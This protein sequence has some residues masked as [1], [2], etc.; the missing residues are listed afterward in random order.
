MLGAN[1]VARAIYRTICVTPPNWSTRIGIYGSWGSGKTS[2]LNLLES[3][4]KEDQAIVVRFSAWAAS[5]ETGVLRQFYDALAKELEK[6]GTHRPKMAQAKR[7]VGKLRGYLGDLKGIAKVAEDW[8]PLPKGTADAA[9]GVAQTAFE[10]FAINKADLDALA[11]NLE[12]R[13]VVVF[14]D[15][16][17][18]ADPKLIPKTLLALREMLDW[19]NFSFVL[20]F[21]RKVVGSALAEY[22]K[23]YGENAQMFLEK[24]VDVPFEIAAPTAPQKLALASRAFSTCCSFVPA[25]IIDS[26]KVHLPD[27]PRRVKLV[28]RKIGVMASAAARHADGELD[29]RSIV[30]YNIVH[31]ASA[32][33]ARIVVEI[34]T[35]DEG[36]SSWLNSDEHKEEKIKDVAGKLHPAFARDTPNDAERPLKA[37][38]ELLTHWQRTEADAIKYQIRLAF[39]EPTFTA[40]EFEAIVFGGSTSPGMDRIASSVNTATTASGGP[41][42]SAANDLVQLSLQRYRVALSDM[43]DASVES[44]REQAMD[45]AGAILAFVEA[46]QAS[47]DPDVSTAMTSGSTASTL[48]SIAAHWANWTHNSGEKDLR[49]REQALAMIVATNCINQEQVYADTD[50]FWESHHEGDGPLPDAW[51]A[52]IRK[53]LQGPIFERLFSRVP[54]SGGITNVVRGDEDQGLQ[55][56]LLESVKSPLYSERKLSSAL[57]AQFVSTKPPSDPDS[58]ARRDSAKEYLHLLLGES[59]SGSWGGKEKIALVVENAPTLIVTA[60][61]AIARCPVPLRMISSI[62]KLRTEL[63]K[64]GVPAASLPVPRWLTAGIKQLRSIET[65]RSTSKN[66]AAEQGDS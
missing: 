48:V 52:K 61:Q 2:I 33:A 35:Q 22:S 6:E 58:I 59:R 53:K 32:E 13:R 4:A 63:V 19:P 10:A 29:W 20:A 28:A 41:R 66:K 49:K 56:W 54:Q 18:R 16:L 23:A 60:W 1:L 5:G 62:E 25:Q 26:V 3:L 47:T 9:F 21:D 44:D 37:A 34:A 45:R 51:R 40:K 17:D 36:W 50:P 55:T 11:Q 43:S 14:I 12:G 64:Y 42:S 31:E 57:A 8:S 46:L 27:E 65:A 30:L 24:V 15:D 39:E 7:F 38:L